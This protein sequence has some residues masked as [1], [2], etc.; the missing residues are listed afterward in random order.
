MTSILKKLSFWKDKPNINYDP[1]QHFVLVKVEDPRLSCPPTLKPFEKRSDKELKKA[2]VPLYPIDTPIEGMFWTCTRRDGHRH[3][4][5][6]PFK[7]RCERYMRAYNSPNSLY[8]CKPKESDKYRICGY[9][10]PVRLDYTKKPPKRSICLGCGQK[11]FQRITG[12][13]I[14]L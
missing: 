14:I 2:G 9:Y 10:S 3:D 5:S 7:G 1:P 12:P 6:E 11:S 4:K 13:E 8:I